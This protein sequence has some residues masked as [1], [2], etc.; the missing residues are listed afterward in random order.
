MQAFPELIEFTHCEQNNNTALKL[1]ESRHGEQP[2]NQRRRIAVSH[3]YWFVE[4]VPVP[5]SESIGLYFYINQTSADSNQGSWKRLDNPIDVDNDLANGLMFEVWNQAHYC[6][7]RRDEVD[8]REAFLQ[9]LYDN[10]N[11]QNKE[12]LQNMDSG[13]YNITTSILST[14]ISKYCWLMKG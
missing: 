5:E 2:C 13:V 7:F 6:R 8:G 14:L 3:A 10:I 9:A 4:A 1:Y 11:E 12:W